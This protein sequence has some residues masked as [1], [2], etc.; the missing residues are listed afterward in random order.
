MKI[1]LKAAAKLNLTLDVT[2]KRHDGYHELRSIMQSVG[3]FEEVTLEENNSGAITI[4]C[5]KAGVP[6]DESNI[7]V[8][9]ADAYFKA[10]K[11]ECRGLHIDIHKNIPMQAGLAGGSADGAAVLFGLNAMHKAFTPEQLRTIGASVGADIPFCLLGGTALAEGIGEKLT[12]LE[13]IPDC[14]FVIVKPQIGISTAQAYKAVDSHGMNMNPSTDIMLKSMTSPAD[15]AAKLHN[16][17]EAALSLDEVRSACSHLLKQNGCLGAQ[18]TGS[19]SAVFGIFD[20]EDK[21][22][23]AKSSLKTI[24][25]FAMAV[26]PCDSGIEIINASE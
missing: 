19:G 18:M 23:A 12:V 14:A 6:C 17:F 24:Y 3:L 20:D 13:D 9:C 8:K 11:S 5:D 21:A 26:K 2:A 15:I 10:A 7:A 4:S 22:R 1:T 25:P 16:D